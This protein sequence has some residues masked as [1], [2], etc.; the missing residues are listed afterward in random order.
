M[1]DFKTLKYGGCS[2][3]NKCLSFSFAT[4]IS[5]AA[6]AQLISSVLNDPLVLGAG[7]GEV[8]MAGGV[9]HILVE[10]R[11]EVVQS[12]LRDI[13]PLGLGLGGAHDELVAVHLLCDGDAVGAGVDLGVAAE[14]RDGIIDGIAERGSFVLEL[15]AAS[16]GAD[17][18]GVKLDQ[19]VSATNGTL[20]ILE[21]A[22]RRLDVSFEGSD[23]IF[24]LSLV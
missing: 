8:K 16:R 18:V 5:A 20:S 1:N 17:G 13:V 12:I 2:E 11:G 19:A 7:L 24:R 14:A 6:V 21:V 23:L 15:S 4:C 9:H 22:Q 10:L 3:C